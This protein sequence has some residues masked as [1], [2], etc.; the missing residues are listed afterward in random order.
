MRTRTVCSTSATSE[1][2][3]RGSATKTG[4]SRAAGRAHAA[5]NTA[6]ERRVELQVGGAA[7]HNDDR[8]AFASALG[9]VADNPAPVEAE[10]RAH[11]DTADLGQEL[12]VVSD[13]AAQFVRE[14]QHPLAQRDVRENVVEQVI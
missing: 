4:P 11:E 14:R 12:A 2:E 3:S 10:H 8:A 9:R 13:T 1:V 5:T 6:A 7:R